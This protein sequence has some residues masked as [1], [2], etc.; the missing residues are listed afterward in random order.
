M[1]MTAALSHYEIR[2]EEPFPGVGRGAPKRVDLWLRPHNGGNPM[3]IEAGDFAVGKIHRDL[4]KI[5]ALNPNGQNW[6]LAFFRT[7]SLNEDLVGLIKQSFERKNGL[8]KNKVAYSESLIRT[9]GV[10]RRV[11]LF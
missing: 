11:C 1:L 8:D 3:L 7:A 6:F 2:H 10:F 4:E 5:R 9:F